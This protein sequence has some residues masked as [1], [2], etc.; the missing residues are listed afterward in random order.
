MLPSATE[1]LEGL[2]LRRSARVATLWQR[3]RRK[4]NLPIAVHMVLRRAFFEYVDGSDTMCAFWTPKESSVRRHAQTWLALPHNIAARTERRELR[5]GVT[6][7]RRKNVDSSLLFS[8][9]T[10][11]RRHQSLTTAMQLFAGSTQEQRRMS[12]HIKRRPLRQ[13]RNR[14]RELCEVFEEVPRG[15]RMHILV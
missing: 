3:N 2:L 5:S 8:I 15:S 12:A 4:T 13:F 9:D 6:D 14:A 7:R 10:V 1:A 11:K